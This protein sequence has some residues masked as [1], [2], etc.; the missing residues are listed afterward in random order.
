MKLTGM[1]FVTVSAGENPK[2]APEQKSPLYMSIVTVP[3]ALVLALVSVAVSVTVPDTG[4]IIV[5]E[6]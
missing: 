3:P 6:S 1:P 2:G 5:A 4:G